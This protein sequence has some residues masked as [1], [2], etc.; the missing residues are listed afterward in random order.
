MGRIGTIERVNFYSDGVKIM[1]MDISKKDK[2]SVITIFYSNMGKNREAQLMPFVYKSGFYKGVLT[3]ND[4]VLYSELTDQENASNVWKEIFELP[5]NVNNTS[6][7][8]KIR[9]TVKF[10]KT[11]TTDKEVK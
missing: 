7:T 11:D 4:F 1:V 3:L 9:K 5:N 2:A 10:K 6:K 8:G